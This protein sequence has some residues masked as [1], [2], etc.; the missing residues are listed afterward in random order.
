MD[1][2]LNPARPA[3]SRRGVLRAAVAAPLVVLPR[4]GR[5]EERVRLLGLLTGLPLNDPLMKRNAAGVPA[6]RF[7][8][9]ITDLEKYGWIQGRNLRFEVRSSAGG[10]EARERAV[11]ELI[12]LKPDVLLTVSST[13][14]AAL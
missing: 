5:S 14:T 6:E 7:Q 12:D 2:R 4:A 10:P 8:I 9:L 13:E 1:A 3:L 11:R